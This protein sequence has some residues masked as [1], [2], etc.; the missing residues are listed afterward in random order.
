MLGLQDGRQDVGDGWFRFRQVADQPLPR[1]SPQLPSADS[2]LP[3]LPSPAC[4]PPCLQ[5]H[6]ACES[7]N[8]RLSMAGLSRR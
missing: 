5:A 1:A 3:R 4:L 8:L 2:P 7:S 6:D